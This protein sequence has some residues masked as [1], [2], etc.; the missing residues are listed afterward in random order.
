M[1]APLYI[2]ALTLAAPGWACG[3][4]VESPWIRAAPPNATALAGYANFVN[5]TGRPI[6]IV[7]IESV[8]FA[9]SEAH[10]TRVEEGMSKMRQLTSF[11]IPP[12][13]ALQFTPGGKHLMLMQ[14][15]G[16]LN[17]GDEVTVVFKDANRCATEATFTV[18]D[19]APGAQGERHRRSDEDPHHPHAEP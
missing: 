18:G 13:G 17:P 8:V 3:L 15:K 7:G 16:P 6:R 12:L 1:R 9:A 10:E 14:P 11:E 2:L 19:A 5:V 4:K